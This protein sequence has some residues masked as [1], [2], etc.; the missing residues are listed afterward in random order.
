MFAKSAAFIAA[1]LF[2]ACGAV[3]ASAQ[4]CPH[5]VSPG[6]ETSSAARALQGQ[7]THH[8]GIRDW[9][10]LKLD[11]AVCGQRLIQVTVSDDR[12]ER[13]ERLRGCRVQSWGKIDFSPTGYYSLDLFQNVTRLRPVGACVQQPLFPDYSKVRPDRHV[14]SY[15]VAM[16]VDYRPGDHPVMFTVR[17]GRRALHPW[18]AYASY[19]LTGGFVLYGLCGEGFVVDQIYGP[20]A[21]RPAHF[22][23]S[24]DS[25][26]MAMFDPETAA[27]SGKTDLHL[28]YSCIRAR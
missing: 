10:E 13:L 15:R 8:A 25:G 1:L 16:H 9:Y 18:Q 6:A 14:R 27:R 21:A 5:A 12:W 19:M 2:L 17:G 26:D 3:P 28:G 24:R 7:L 11:R 20:R 22:T 23:A 4:H